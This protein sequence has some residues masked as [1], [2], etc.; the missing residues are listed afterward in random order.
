MHGG[1][2][3]LYVLASGVPA[4][5]PRKGIGYVDGS[6]SAIV[7]MFLKERSSAH[8]DCARLIACAG[9]STRAPMPVPSARV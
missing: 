3:Q 1:E 2:G 9:G 8:D 7:V 6:I 4:F 5:L